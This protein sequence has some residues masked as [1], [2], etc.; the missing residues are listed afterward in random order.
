MDQVQKNNQKPTPLDQNQQQNTAPV[1][2]NPISS[3]NPEVGPIQEVE[4]PVSAYTS[5]P[6]PPANMPPIVK[7]SEIIK[8]SDDVASQ[9]SLKIVQGRMTVEEALKKQDGPINQSVTW[10]ANETLMEDKKIKK[11]A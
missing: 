7:S 6:L 2:I 4:K 3:G 5:Y 1:V 9:P 10:E 8:I 11:A